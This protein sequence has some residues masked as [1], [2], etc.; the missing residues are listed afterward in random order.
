MR[1][2]PKS[3]STVKEKIEPFLSLGIKRVFFCHYS[4]KA[5][6]FSNQYF[7]F[8]VAMVFIAFIIMTI[9]FNGYCL[10]VVRG[11]SDFNNSTMVLLQEYAGC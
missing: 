7:G 6:F 10:L 11:K 5:F 3:K 8:I 4:D 9:R 1:L 2:Q